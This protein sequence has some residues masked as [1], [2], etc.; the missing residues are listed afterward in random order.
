MC[1]G[2]VILA[3]ATA[4]YGLAVSIPGVYIASGLH[5]AALSFI[6]VSSLGLLSTFPERTTESMAGIEVSGAGEG[7]L[8][9]GGRGGGTHLLL[10][11]AI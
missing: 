1:A 10:A 9:S 4:L 8:G 6:H 7:G 11:L 5:G 3:V 2:L